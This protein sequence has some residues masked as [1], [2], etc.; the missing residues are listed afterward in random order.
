[1]TLLPGLER[2][3][4]ADHLGGSSGSVTATRRC[5]DELADRHTQAIDAGMS[6]PFDDWLAEELRAAAIGM[7]SGPIAVLG[8]GPAA[9]AEAF[10]GSEGP[11]LLVDS[12]PDMLRAARLRIRGRPGVRFVLGDAQQFLESGTRPF[13]AIIAVGELLSYLDEPVRFLEL[14]AARLHENG[15]FVMTFMDQARLAGR[16]PVA[17]GP[18]HR[19]GRAY[20]ERA[21]LESGELVCYG[22]EKAEV[23][24]WAAAQGLEP[25]TSSTGT[26]ARV[27]LVCRRSSPDVARATTG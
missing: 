8:C 13:G 20:V 14:A 3:A 18:A 2:R 7:P 6:S 17:R 4:V 26:S 1:M 15:L 11:V 12:S 25:I 19:W 9:E 27:G 23:W 10:L 21:D 5:F 24:A 16:L 22:Y